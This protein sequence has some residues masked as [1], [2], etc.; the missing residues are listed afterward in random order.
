MNEETRKMIKKD[1]MV[2][3]NIKRAAGTICI[4]GTILHCIGTSLIYRSFH[5]KGRAEAYHQVLDVFEEA[6]TE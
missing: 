5:M 4:I 3:D 1:R 2:A 6:R